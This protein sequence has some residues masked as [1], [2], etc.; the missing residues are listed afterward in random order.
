MFFFQK[1]NTNQKLGK[2]YRTHKRYFLLSI[3][4][5]HIPLVEA[6]TVAP[7]LMIIFGNTRSMSRANIND[8]QLDE[9]QTSTIRYFDTGANNG[10]GTP[11]YV[12]S[13]HPESKFVAAKK[14]LSTLLWK[15]VAGN[16]ISDNINFGFA[17]FR[18]SFGFDAVAAVLKSYL[19]YPSIYLKNTKKTIWDG[20]D[21]ER[22]AADRD[23]YSFAGALWYPFTTRGGKGTYLGTEIGYRPKGCPSCIYDTNAR[24]YDSASKTYIE[25]TNPISLNKKI[26]DDTSAKYLQGGGLI[27]IFKSRA[28]RDI[29]Y[30]GDETI[31][32]DLK[33]GIT[34]DAD[35]KNVYNNYG[36]TG[37]MR[38]PN[39]PDERITWKLCD[40]KYQPSNNYYMARYVG[41]KAT[42]SYWIEFGLHATWGGKWPSNGLINNTKPEWCE[43]Y[44]DNNGQPIPKKNSSGAIIKDTSGNIVYEGETV[45]SGQIWE[46]LSNQENIIGKPYMYFSAIGTYELRAWDATQGKP[47]E[48]YGYFSGWSGETSFK[49]TINPYEPG[50][51]DVDIPRVAS[52]PS[53]PADPSNS[54]RAWAYEPT[55]GRGIKT[56]IKHMGVFLNLPEPSL[57]YRDQREVINSFLTLKSMDDSGLEY[58]PNLGDIHDLDSHFIKNSA[59]VGKGISTSS[60]GWASNDSPVY[61]TLQDAYAYYKAYKEADKAAGFDACRSNNIL[62]FY[63]GKENAHWQDTN[64]QRVFAKPEL[65]SGKLLNDLGVKTYVVILNTQAGYV[66]EANRV[67]AAGGTG[68]AYSVNTSE[69]L[70][71]AFRK[72]I[73]DVGSTI[74][75]APPVLPPSLPSTGGLAYLLSHET[76]PGAGYVSAYKVSGKGVVSATPEWEASS[77]MSS[78]IRSSKLYS[79][80]AQTSSTNWSANVSTLSLLD[81]AAFA[82]SSPAASTIRAYTYD[83]SYASG[84]YLGGR[85]LNSFLGLF[86]DQSM[87]PVLLGSPNNSNTYTDTNYI[88]YTTNTIKTRLSSLLFQNDD[89]FLYS[90][91]PDTGDLNWGWSPRPLVAG[92]KAYKSFWT[93]GAMRGGFTAIDGPIA[94]TPYYATY[95][96]GTGQSGGLH[97]ALRLDSTGK[98]TKVSW[99]DARANNIAPNYQAPLITYLATGTTPPVKPYAYYLTTDHSVSPYKHYINITEVADGKTPKSAVIDLTDPYASGTP[100]QGNPSSEIVAIKDGSSPAGGYSLY[101]GDDQGLL[102]W[103][104]TDFDPLVTASVLGPPGEIYNRREPIIY[105]GNTRWNEVDYLWV[106]GKTTITMFAYKYTA[107]M[108]SSLVQLWESHVGGA[109]KWDVDGFNYSADNTGVGGSRSGIQSIANG[110]T[111]TDAPISEKGALIVPISQTAS[112]DACASGNAY[113]YLYRLEDG[114]FPSVFS[115][116]KGDG[117]TE[118][119]TDNLFVGRGKARKAAVTT[120]STGK[121]IFGV[122]ER[123]DM[124]D[125]NMMPGIKVNNISRGI[126]SWREIVKP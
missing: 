89:G 63:D 46:K 62:I 113:Y 100:K 105:I 110:F 74:V 42:P 119:L 57:G 95:L 67:A 47:V 3:A 13:D 15:G 115:R 50:T 73:V 121:F 106:A 11:W 85:K 18:Q 98:P 58:N 53:L 114:F 22:T 64:G 80:S 40:I 120:G 97:Y 8:A 26:I 109:G 12:V 38:S 54:K 31:Y 28:F 69:A 123:P 70:L 23:P 72:I 48:D 88:N 86:S 93:T 71:D 16:P 19:I 84:D 41:D 52:Y 21:T 60:Y 27:T 14:Q 65:V 125:G 45:D 17:T 55:G 59:G 92:L 33:R 20:N 34:V 104:I 94:S 66:D 37:S 44:P 107:G 111:I 122:S 2:K 87:A 9:T 43:Y 6:I 39:T 124:S 91:K 117:T 79:N 126:V 82:S 90:I 25:Y 81:D 77:K 118:P 83:P 4:I 76:S 10:K 51:A 1:K 24:V 30:E 5:L 112:V 68:A 101:F 32:P 56:N 75:S 29:G 35:N 102:W 103:S 116:I 96:V 99:I 36:A 61:D 108:G 49:T 78:S 7:N